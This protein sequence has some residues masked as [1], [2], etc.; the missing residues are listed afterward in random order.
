VQTAGYPAIKETSK[1]ALDGRYITGCDM[2]LTNAQ[3][4]ARWQAKHK[5]ELAALRRSQGEASIGHLIEA[6]IE[7]LN[8][9]PPNVRA[10]AVVALSRRLG[11]EVE[12]VAD[13]GNAMPPP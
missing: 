6:L 11:L 4:Q 12:E 1:R 10:Q 3:R 9:Q 13:D 2:A 5:A 8:R 7:A